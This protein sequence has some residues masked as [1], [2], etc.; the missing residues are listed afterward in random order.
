MRIAVRLD[1]IAPIMNWKNFERMMALLSEK[2]AMPLLGVIPDCQDQKIAGMKG[3]TQEE[4]EAFAARMKELKEE[5]VV[6]AMHGAHHVYKTQE[7]GIFPLNKA[8]EFA[9][10]PIEEQQELLRV[11]TEAMKAMGL[12]TDI[13]MA[14]SHSYDE[15]TLKALSEAGFHR[16][17]DGFGNSPYRYHGLTFYP[18]AFS[19][20]RALKSKNNGTVTVVYHVN[21]MRNRDFAEAERFLGQAQ[22]IPYREL[23]FEPTSRRMDMLQ[24]A[25]HAAAWCKRAMLSR[26]KRGKRP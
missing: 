20:S 10:L 22:L 7:G 4:P 19:K 21:T 12:E 17:T 6:I 25:E 13:F 23:L 26:R 16:I 9:G 8:S 3:V 11:G 5:G 14:P 2:N 24:R 15:N 1:D 18:I